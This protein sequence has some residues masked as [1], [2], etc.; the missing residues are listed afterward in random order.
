M[1][2]TKEIDWEML[3]KRNPDRYLSVYDENTKELIEVHDK[4]NGNV[5]FKV[6]NE[7]MYIR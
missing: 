5:W 6:G 1:I 2:Q 4:E 3:F 7:W